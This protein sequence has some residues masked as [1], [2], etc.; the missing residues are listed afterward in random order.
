MYQKLSK[1]SSPSFL[2]PLWV[3]KNEEKEENMKK[4]QKR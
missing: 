3:Y 2:R 1:E 4:A